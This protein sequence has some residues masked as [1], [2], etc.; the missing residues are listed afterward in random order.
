VAKLAWNPRY[1]RKLERRLRR[2]SC[3]TLIIGAE[4]DR[5]LGNEQADRFAE[6]IPGAKLTRI[7]GTGHAMAV[8]QPEAVAQAILD[9][10]GGA[11]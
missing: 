11:A 4:D 5:L 8:E 6:L 1:D 2:V 10:Q 7:P 3:P 9:F